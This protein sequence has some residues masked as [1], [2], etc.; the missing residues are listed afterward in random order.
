MHP[1]HEA[2]RTRRAVGERAGSAMLTILMLVVVI[3]VAVAG[4]FSMIE[5]ERK[6]LGDHEAQQGAYDLARSGYDHFMANPTGT[7]AGFT[8]P[9]WTGPDSLYVAL[10]GGYAW[11]KVERIRPA[12]GTDGALYLV[13]SRGVRTSYRSGNTPAAERIFAQYAQFNNA[14]PALAA[15][16]SLTGLTKTGGSGVISG[17][18]GCSA[19]P[20]VGGVAVPTTPGYS[21]SGGSSVPSG[22]PNILDMGPQASANSMIDIDWPGIV[23]GTALTPDLTIPG[24]SWPSFASTTYWPV[25]YVNQTGEFTLPSD[26]RG[27]LI[28]RHDARLNGSLQWDGI[29]LVGGALTSSGNN[30]VQGAVVTG[31]NVM[32]GETAGVSDL[33]SGTKT[34]AF[35]SCNVASATTRFGGLV[36]LRNT[37]VDNWPAY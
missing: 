19:T 2:R 25:I 36:A 23:A 27:L 35:N 29:I 1:N 15:W 20:P 18:D 3:S 14:M 37:S 26:G 17:T 12:I 33:G 28:V 13:R 24:A 9:T 22:S 7:L 32:L 6:S 10:S 4:T 30:T 21:Q 11:V 16:T 31:L 5:S 8:P 34:F